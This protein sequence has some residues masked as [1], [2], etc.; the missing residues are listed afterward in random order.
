MPARSSAGTR[1]G[2]ARRGSIENLSDQR[3]AL[4]RLSIVLLFSAAERGRR[5]Y[6]PRPGASC[7]RIEQAVPALGTK[8]PLEGGNAYRLGAR[9]HA[10]ADAG[11]IGERPGARDDPDAM[12]APTGEIGRRLGHSPMPARASR[13]QSNNSPGSD[14][15]SGAIS[16]WP[17]HAIERDAVA[18][19]KRTAKL[20]DR[21]HLLLGKRP[22]APFVA[23][24]DDLDADRHRVEVAF[25]RPARE[26]GVKCPP[27]LG[28]E[29]PDCPVLLD[30]IV[31]AD[32]CRRD[33]TAVRAPLA[34][35]MPV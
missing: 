21:R 5:R 32:P 13:G 10:I 17:D 23:G 27:R 16:E 8:A 25:A 34:L 24:I 6:A 11:E 7:L 15:R 22:I 2:D 19:E 29:P 26:A 20:L 3:R 33:R 14:L 1:S 4:P 9:G 18:R 30:D 12:A 31:G 35:C 28:N